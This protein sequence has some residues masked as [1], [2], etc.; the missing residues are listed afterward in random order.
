MSNVS[1]YDGS[2]NTVNDPL[3]FN[4]AR[5]SIPVYDDGLVLCREAIPVNCS[6]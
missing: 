5:L 1:I 6:K 2:N 3:S 4:S